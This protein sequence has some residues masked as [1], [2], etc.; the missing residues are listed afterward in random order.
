MKKLFLL[1]LAAAFGVAARAQMGQIGRHPDI[2]SD[3]E[4]AFVELTQ[5]NVAGLVKSTYGQYLGQL[6]AAGQIYGFG[7][8]FTDQ[9]GEVYGQFRNGNLVMGIRMGGGIV[10]VG[11]TDHCTV[12]DLVTGEAAYV[13]KDGDK[14]ALNAEHKQ[15]WKFQ[16]ITYKN[17]ASYVG[18]TVGGKRDGYGL[19]YYTNGDYYYGRYADDRPVGYGAIFKSDNHVVI[20][21]WTTTTQ[22]E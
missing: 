21:D 10:K 13:L 22:T 1:L 14:Y 6:T 5:G 17:G 12:Y 4:A 3:Y 11:T 15:T 8:F 7:A 16:K 20:E 9:D 19:Y 2:P 18:E